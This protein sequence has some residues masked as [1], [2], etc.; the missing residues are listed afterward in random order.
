MS[1]HYEYLCRCYKNKYVYIYINTEREGGTEKKP[2]DF[3]DKI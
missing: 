1:I 2:P 3:Q